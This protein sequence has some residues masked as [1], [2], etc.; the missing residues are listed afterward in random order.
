M[1]NIVTIDI[2]EFKIEPSKAT[3]IKATF[4]PMVQMLETFE[5]KYNEVL[6]SASNGITPQ[7]SA[8]A[9][10]LRL[11]IAKVRIDAEK[12]RKEMKDEYLRAGQAI[13]GANNILKWAVTDR[14]NKLK[15]IEEHAERME[16]ERIAKLQ[17]ERVEMLSPFVPDA[18]ARNLS[19]MDEDVWNAYLNTKKQEHQDRIDAEKK[20]EQERIAREQSEAE[21]RERQRAEN[22]RLKAE[23]EAREKELQAVQAKLKAEAEAREKELQAVQAKLKAEAE[24]RERI[25][26]EADRKERDRLAQIEA[27][28]KAK[29]EAE[30]KAKS[31]PDIEKLKLFAE[32]IAS[33]QAP[34]VSGDEA[35]KIITDAMGLLSK[36]STF[37]TEKSAN[38]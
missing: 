26:A 17:A 16:A 25:Q 37:I 29:S 18:E 14:E 24:E 21:E 32:Q 27:E 22:E 20:A 30:H 28:A 6:E 36:V 10:R 13:D 15:E 7:V 4:E 23:A 31:A 33:I 35:K 11:D 12:A 19:G 1:S 5:Q 3:Q 34:E 8:S 38:I 9:K 2:T